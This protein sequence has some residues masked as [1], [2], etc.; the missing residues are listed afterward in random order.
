MGDVNGDLSRNRKL[1]S[2]QENFAQA[3][4]DLGLVASVTYHSSG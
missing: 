4:V 2:R 3:I 1:T